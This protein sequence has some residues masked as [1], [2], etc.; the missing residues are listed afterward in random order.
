MAVVKHRGELPL[1]LLKE[2]HFFSFSL[3]KK[4]PSSRHP[5]HFAVSCGLFLLFPPP[6]W[7]GDSCLL[8]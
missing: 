3:Y 1:G 7:R 5:Y 8:L 2:E 4:L 6:L